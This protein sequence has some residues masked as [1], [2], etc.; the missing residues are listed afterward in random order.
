MLGYHHT[1]Q[2]DDQMT[3]FEARKWAAAEEEKQL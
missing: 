1:G 3:E 2:R